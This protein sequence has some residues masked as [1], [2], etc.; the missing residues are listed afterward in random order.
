MRTANFK[1]SGMSCAACSARVEKGV[2]AL[3][4]VM[5]ADVNLLLGSMRVSYDEAQQSE[6]GII[7]AV[8]GLGYGAELLKEKATAT[9]ENRA[10]GIRRRFLSSIIILIPLVL[11]HHL[12]HGVISDWVQLALTL[13]VLILNRAFFVNGFRSLLKG[14][15]NMDTLVGL[16][17]LAA[18]VDGGMEMCI[19]HRGEVYFETAA[20]ILT[21]ITLG[22]WLEARATAKTS[23][24]LDK[25]RD[26]LPRNAILLRNGEQHEC[27]VESI[28]PGETIL[29][30]P[31]DRI[32][33]DGLVTGGVSTVDESA[34]TGE[35]IPAEKCAGSEVHAGTL[36]R[37][38]TLEVRVERTS[39]QSTLADIIRLTGEAAGTKAPI[40]RLADRIAG[41]FVPVVVTLAVITT[42][43]W[44]LCGAGAAF[45]L[46]CGIAV[47][48][49]S[50]PCAL[51][52]ATPVAIMTGSGRGAESGILFRHGEALENASQVQAIVLDKTGT[53]T[54]G[55]T[56]VQ[57]ILP[58]E[59][60]TKERLLSL[61]AS[62]E[63]GG[64]HPLA[65]AVLA[66]AG[67]AERHPAI[68]AT[69]R[70]GLGITATI[71]GM[72]CAA[73]NEKL[74]SELGISVPEAT[75][76]R[77]A[78]KTVLYFAEGANYAGLMTVADSIRPDSAQAVAIWKSR[79]IRVLMLTGDNPVTAQAIAC[80]A[81]ISEV[82]AEVLP[83]DKESQV[84]ALQAEGLRVA[85]IGDGINDAPALT[86][87]DIGIAI[88]AGTD[89]AIES[90]D[91]ILLHN[92]L[93][94]AERALQLSRHTIHNIRQNLGLAFFYN[95]L[96]I[97]LAAGAFY[98]L[99]GWLLHPAIGAAA[100]GMS[101]FCVVTNAL[102]LR[103]LSLELPET[104]T[105]MNTVTIKVDGMMCPHCEAH[106]VKAISALP[107]VE[108]C[109]A[110]H[111]AKEVKV[112][113]S[114]DINAVKAAITECGYTVLS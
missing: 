26:L 55:R 95:I 23:E 5:K 36:N 33:L 1:V 79:G 108:S 109:T 89:I 101:S 66:R 34:L 53:I 44:L 17:A 81:G 52:L 64:N 113:G 65:E 82:H 107:G 96:A 98:P 39:E 103:H 45:A 88:G 87:A 74:L 80:Q 77:Q 104:K 97:P 102:R 38:G 40:S 93:T 61:A 112:S 2:R 99:F 59:G 12:W 35:S 6:Q 56:E 106:V 21:L 19:H 18:L 16:G 100:M 92:K 28:P 83:G 91:I 29:I 48:V 37:N 32:P 31:G 94:D 73:G 63:Q 3:A 71:G 76:F 25:L 46:S 54:S 90:A 15:P 78:G 110:S 58:A 24:A 4:G 43:V 14:A 51:G 60:Y 57:D 69:Y 7:Q 30:R 68:N 75:N 13:P 11:I 50:C 70:P 105:T 72:L 111:T 41:V 10:D 85:M 62:L 47:L 20:M 67:E 86:R 27:P 49:I 84:R 114:A 9:K 8:T 42:T 22:K